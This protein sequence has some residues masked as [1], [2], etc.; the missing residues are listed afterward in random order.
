MYISR[1]ELNMI[2][3][4]CMR[5]MFSGSMG[6]DE[7][8]RQCVRAAKEM[9]PKSIGLCQQVFESPR[10][11]LPFAQQECT[12]KLRAARIEPMQKAC[13]CMHNS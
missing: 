12:W 7:F 3:L 13:L 8:A 10:C 2:L 4:G 5:F 11:R 1:H 9:D 6:I